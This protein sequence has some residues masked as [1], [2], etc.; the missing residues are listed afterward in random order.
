MRRSFNSKALEGRARSAGL[1]L[2]VAEY[3]PGWRT[4]SFI[5]QGDAMCVATVYSRGT[6]E[7]E[8]WLEGYIAALQYPPAS[9]GF[10]ASRVRSEA[11]LP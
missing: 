9:H 2:Q 5:R 10:R 11:G 4:Y 6:K 3:A 8:Q 7:P 1:S